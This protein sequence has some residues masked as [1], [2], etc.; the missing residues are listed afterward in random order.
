MKKALGCVLMVALFIGGV[1]PVFAA[2]NTRTINMEINIGLGMSGNS[3]I[4]M[5]ELSNVLESVEYKSNPDDPEA[6]DNGFF[7]NHDTIVAIAPCV[8]TFKGAKMDGE[9]LYKPGWFYVDVLDVEPEL[10]YELSGNKY[11]EAWSAEVNGEI[12]YHL[13]WQYRDI[14]NR[15]DLD[16][17]IT[18]QSGFYIM[19][20][21]SMG[22][23]SIGYIEVR[24]ADAA[25]QGAGTSTGTG[26]GAGTDLNTNTGAGAGDVDSSATAQATP[27]ASTVLVNGED[28]AFDAYNIDDFNYFKLR[29]LA[30]VLT[31]TG[32]R[33]EVSWD[34][35]N[36][37]ISLIG[38]EAYTVVGG[39][40]GGGE[41]AG[42]EAGAG[43]GVG[44]AGAA[45]LARPTDSKILLD[46]VEI[47]LSAY[48]IDGNNYFKLR[49]VGEA[50][51]F[52][53]DWDEDSGTVIIEA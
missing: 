48:L 36:N 43:S 30:F 42:S 35:K 14:A 12:E 47:S 13:I 33:F 40:M 15:M 23:S 49:D 22:S 2:E 34:D 1:M 11:G 4:E 10:F 21:D 18:L 53:V 31:G 17:S 8:I 19:G 44:D 28:I 27:T 6:F 5:L 46:G 29:D 38:G 32:S 24:D 39:E 37:A 20:Y 26:A 9:P 7:W 3:E 41:A 16:G 50:I 25:Q 45:K 52:L 51:G